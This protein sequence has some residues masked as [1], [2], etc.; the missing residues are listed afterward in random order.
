MLHQLSHHLLQFKAFVNPC[1]FCSNEA[2]QAYSD[3]TNSIVMSLKYVSFIL[4]C[5][6]S[7]SL[8]IN[9][10]VYNDAE[11]EEC[12]AKKHRGLQT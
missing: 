3:I 7:A 9:K 10:Y 2:L 5:N 4:I 12:C 8:L 11:K 1:I 6:L